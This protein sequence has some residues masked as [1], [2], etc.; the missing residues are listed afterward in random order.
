MRWSWIAVVLFAGVVVAAC[1][2]ATG[3]DLPTATDDCAA[4]EFPQVQYGSHLLGDTE[5]PVPYSSTPP[6]S[7][8]HASGPVAIQP[9][10]PSNALSGP[11]QVSILEVGGIVVTYDDLPAADIDMLTRVAETEYAGRV[12]VTP[13]PG[14]PDGRVAYAGWGVLQRCTDVDPAA[15]ET[16]ATA[17]GAE[18][19]AEPGSDMTPRT[20]GPIGGASK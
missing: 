9:F 17:Y 19:P 16:F 18:N 20:E 1:G 12:A 5:P 8:W 10:G 6:T 15:L 2:D 4:P 3:A 13:V 11:Q 14:L 7:G